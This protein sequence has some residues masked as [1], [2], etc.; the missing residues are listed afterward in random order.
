[1]K[2]FLLSST[3]LA[4]CWCQAQKLELRTSY[5]TPSIYGV[6]QTVLDALGSGITA[7]LT[8]NPTLMY[9]VSNGAFNVSVQTNSQNSNWRWGAEM[10]FESFDTSSSYYTHLSF[11]SI[12]PK[13]DY[14]WSNAESKLRFYSGV[15][16]GLTFRNSKYI[17]S[18]GVEEK[19]NDSFFAFNLMPIGLR[20]GKE[21]GV[22]VEPNIGVKSFVQAG[23]SYQF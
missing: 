2:K 23:I 14:F 5:G 1:M 13:A 8:N 9:P 17:S 18:A 7:A 22:F 19:S 16:A 4:V 20:Y 15:A 11:M 3:L 21:L 6:S 10:V 12:M